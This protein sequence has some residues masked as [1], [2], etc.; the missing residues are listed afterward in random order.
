MSEKE[1]K[2]LEKAS[3]S[4]AEPTKD[5]CAGITDPVRR[6]LCRVCQAPVVGQAPF[7]KDHEPPTP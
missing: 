4:N 7:C 3:V 6:G 1:E 2:D 5:P